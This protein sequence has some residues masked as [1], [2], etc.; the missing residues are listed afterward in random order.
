MTIQ[1]D[2][3]ED[4]KKGVGQRVRIARGKKHITQEQLA[5]ML[6]I[7]K[8]AVSHIES[9]KNLPSIG[10]LIVIA[11]KLDVQPG[12]ILQGNYRKSTTIQQVGDVDIYSSIL[13]DKANI[14][15]VPNPAQAGIYRGV[16]DAQHINLPKLYIPGFESGDDTFLFHVEGESMYP[17]LSNGDMVVAVKIESADEIKPGFAYVICTR[18]MLVVKRIQR[19]D[20][21]NKI[22]LVSDNPEVQEAYKQHVDD[23]TNIF[24]VKGAI[25]TNTS[26]R[27]ILGR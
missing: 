9:G 10:R 17:F 22:L 24:L 18:E 21:P 7:K 19:I 13:P 14:Y 15:Y 16:F 11:E 2:L 3:A 6:G 4:F 23:I 25:T 27:F 12:W 1:D 20:E 5:E 26:K 8:A